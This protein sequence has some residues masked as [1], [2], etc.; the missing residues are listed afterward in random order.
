[1]YFIGKSQYLY[2]YWCFYGNKNFGYHFCH[3]KVDEWGHIFVF[4][5]VLEPFGF[6]GLYNKHF[7]ISWNKRRIRLTW[8]LVFRFFKP[9]SYY[10]FTLFKPLLILLISASGKC[11]LFYLFWTLQACM[12][13]YQLSSWFLKQLLHLSLSDPATEG[14]GVWF[15]SSLLAR[16]KPG[17]VHYV[18]IQT[19]S[20]Y[21]LYE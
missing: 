9:L 13:S 19:D 1:M 5:F 20:S 12:H 3:S 16:I 10:F 7:N 2:C 14:L 17:R 18:L 8:P 15:L 4:P 11:L 6:G 21:F